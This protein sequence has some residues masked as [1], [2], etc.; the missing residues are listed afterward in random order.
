M[1]EP[2]TSEL[3]PRSRIGCVMT[4]REPTMQTRHEAEAMLDRWMRAT[5]RDKYAPALREPLPETLMRLLDSADR[6][7]APESRG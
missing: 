7:A 6:Q 1:P 5:L 3:P 4:E 2:P